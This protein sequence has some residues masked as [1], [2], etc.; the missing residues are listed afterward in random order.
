MSCSN[1]YWC[2]IQA[3]FKK[4]ANG[5]HSKYFAHHSNS[6]NV[7]IISVLCNVCAAIIWRKSSAASSTFSFLLSFPPGSIQHFKMV[8]RHVNTVINKQNKTRDCSWCNSLSAFSF[9]SSATCQKKKR[10]YRNYRRL[11][12][13]SVGDPPNETRKKRQTDRKQEPTQ[14][15]CRLIIQS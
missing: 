7:C 6:R 4:I 1:S 8:S 13:C 2:K 5:K 15:T 9:V 14:S 12:S 3:P 10:Q 11:E